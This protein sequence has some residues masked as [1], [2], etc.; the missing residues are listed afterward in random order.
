MEAPILGGSRWH[1]LSRVIG[2]PIHKAGRAL[3]REVCRRRRHKKDLMESGC[4]AVDNSFGSRA[5]THRHTCTHVHT[6]AG[7]TQACGTMSNWIYRWKVVSGLFLTNAPY[8]NRVVPKSKTS[9][10]GWKLWQKN[11]R[12]NGQIMV[13]QSHNH[14]WI[15]FY[16]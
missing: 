13:F 9:Q 1:W 4:T 14:F 6:H 11:S 15:I 10:I 16:N 8:S 3:C 2:R 7:I 5:E 12:S